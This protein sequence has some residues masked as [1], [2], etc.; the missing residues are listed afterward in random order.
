VTGRSLA[1]KIADRIRAEGPL[2]VAAYMAMTLYDPELGYYATRRPIGADGDFVTAPEISQ[3][4]GELVGIWCAL[5]WERIGRPDPVILAELGPGNGV[6]A[7]DLLRAARALPEFRRALRLHLIEL[8][9]VLRAAQRRYLGTDNAV[10]LTRIED[11]PEG[12]L[13]IVANEFLDALPIRQLVRGSQHW[14]ERMV[15]LAAEDRFGFVDGPENP[16]LAALVPAA[17]RDTSPPGTIFEICPSGLA[18]A[19]ALGS[20]FTR[21]PGAALLIDYGRTETA[22]GASLRAVSS[23]RRADPLASPGTADLSAEVDFAAIAEA[24]RAV[25]AD[26]YGPIAQCRFLHHLGAGARLA[27][28][29]VRASPEERERLESGLYRLLDPQQMGTLFKVMALTSRGLAEPPGFDDPE[30]R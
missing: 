22:A 29:S 1:G 7:G 21:W 16:L 30:P 10:W 2:S 24:V 12:P 28:L 23:H 4:F 20:R 25:G 6:L 9:P 5:M 19:A 13:L 27:A 18:L 8:S 17:L 26:A 14:T 15:T 3:I 11:L